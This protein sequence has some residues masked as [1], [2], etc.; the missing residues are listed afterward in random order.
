MPPL[1]AGQRELA[2][3]IHGLAVDELQPFGG[4]RRGGGRDGNNGSRQSAAVD[5]TTPAA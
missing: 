2:T 4:Q 3:R 5:I 1:I